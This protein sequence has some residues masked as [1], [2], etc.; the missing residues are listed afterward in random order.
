VEELAASGTCDVLAHPDLIRVTGRRPAAP[1]E[2][3]DRLVEAA[4]A[5]GMAAELSSAGWRKP[6]AEA[7]PAPGLLS[8]MVERGVP[9]TTASDAHRLSHVADRS[10]DLAGLLEA[11]GVETLRAFSGRAPRDVVVDG[12]VRLP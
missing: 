3:W 9:L 8:K 10:A 2:C 1:E 4:V 5:S 7:Y 12:G 11:L 6:A